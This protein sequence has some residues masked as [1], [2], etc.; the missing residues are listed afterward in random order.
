MNFPRLAEEEL[1]ENAEQVLRD[2]HL[3][4]VITRNERRVKKGFWAKF[5]R[6]ARK[7]PF[8]E[9][10]VAAYCCATDTATPLK[11]RGI[12]LAALAYFILPTDFIPDFILGFG[13]SDDATVLATAIALVSRH[14]KPEHRRQAQDILSDN[15]KTGSSAA[16]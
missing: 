11:V 14:I 3:P 10:L 7:I 1:E 6:V 8:S 5:K 12:L 9:D 4:M 16:A 2:S 15:D 13:F